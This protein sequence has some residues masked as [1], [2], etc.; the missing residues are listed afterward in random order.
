MN[1]FRDL[2][3]SFAPKGLELFS[4]HRFSRKATDL[5]GAEESG[6]SNKAILRYGEFVKKLDKRMF[7]LNL[8]P[9]DINPLAESYIEALN[10]LDE[11]ECPIFDNYK[12][13]K[14]DPFVVKYLRN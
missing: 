1:H 11:W 13:L 2:R 12:Q 10:G 14:K 7:E 5:Y 3:T 8:T 4:R 6:L 9:T